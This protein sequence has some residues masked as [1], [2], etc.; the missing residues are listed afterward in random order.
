M[1]IS[2]DDFKCML[3]REGCDP[4]VTFWNRSPFCTQLM[5]DRDIPIGS[6]AFTIQDD[7]LRLQ[8]AKARL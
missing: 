6:L 8:F 5:S 3:P 2:T 1:R 4:Q 7:G